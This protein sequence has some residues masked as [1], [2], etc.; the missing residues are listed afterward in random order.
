MS[1]KGRSLPRWP[2]NANVAEKRA[3]LRI[4]LAPAARHDLRELLRWSYENFGERAAGR[5]RVL[6]QQALR[7]LEADPERHGS[8]ERPGMM[9]E[10]A[11]LYHLQFSRTRVSG[12]GVKEPR[13][14]VLYRR[15][16]EGMIEVGRILHDSCDVERHLPGRFRVG[17]EV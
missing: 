17:S 11:R 7:D 4:T 14:F 5:Y 6:R 1:L 10:G 15:R 12:V 8:M 3:P 2:P 13:H 9:I 16:G